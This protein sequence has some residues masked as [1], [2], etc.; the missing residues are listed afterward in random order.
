VRAANDFGCSKEQITITNI[1]G[2]SYRAEGCGQNVV[3]DCTGSAVQSGPGQMGGVTSN[4]VCVPETPVR[5]PEST[6]SHPAKD[7]EQTPQPAESSPSTAGNGAGD[8]DDCRQAFRQID[9]VVAAWHEWFP[10]R[11]P[12]PTP[13]RMEFLSVCHTLSPEQ[14]ACLNLPYGRTHHSACGPLFDMLAPSYRAR[15]DGLFFAPQASK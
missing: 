14:Q 3:Y 15:L 10:D 2:T 7:V 9:D 6:A 1:G 8:S 5:P 12:K 13:S 11:E 4:Y